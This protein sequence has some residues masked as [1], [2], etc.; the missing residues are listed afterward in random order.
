MG[1]WMSG[2]IEHEDSEGKIMIKISIR[3]RRSLN[4]E[5]IVGLDVSS[6]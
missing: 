2:G 5:S 4:V 3:C 1:G 6:V